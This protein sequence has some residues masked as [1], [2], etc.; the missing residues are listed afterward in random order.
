VRVLVADDDHALLESI[1]GLLAEE[2]QFELVAT[3][4]HAHEAIVLALEHQP[5]VALIDV[6]MPGGGP[7]TASQ[8]RAGSPETAVVAL[9]ADGDRDSV[10]RMIAAGSSGY[11]MKGGTAREIIEALERAARRESTLSGDVTGPLPARLN[12]HLRAGERE[13]E[14]RARKQ[15]RVRAALDDGALS[16]VFQPIVHL[17]DS[18]PVGYEA[19]ARFGLEPNRAPDEWFLEAGEVSM[20]EELEV[21]AI[22]RALVALPYIPQDRWL[23]VN[24]APDVVIS[25]ALARALEGHDCSRLVLEIAEAA[26]IEDD[27]ALAAVLPELRSSGLRLAV[28]DAGAGFASLRHILRLAPDLIKLDRTLIDA[29]DTSRASRALVAAFVSF[30]QEVGSLVLAEGIERALQLETLLDLGVTLGQGYRL[31]RPAALG[32]QAA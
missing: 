24:A 17:A 28:D 27:D 1:A 21:G 16:M 11:I 3:A 30:A 13:L 2:G 23:S 14:E 8:I 26:V 20:R 31:G 9:S 15:A 10:M 4:S 5:D 19:L 25:G 12:G 22:A 29:V 32:Q 6:R 7:Y 18:R